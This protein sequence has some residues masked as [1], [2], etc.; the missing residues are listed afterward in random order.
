MNAVKIS[1]LVVLIALLSILVGCGVKTP[2]GSAV[3]PQSSVS[4][5]DRLSYRADWQAGQLDINQQL[6]SG[7]EIMQIIP[8]KG[9]LY[10][11]TSLWMENGAAVSRNCQ[12]LVLDAPDGQWR[13]HHQFASN[14]RLAA[15]AAVTFTT[16][17]QGN[18]ITPVT[19]L[20]AAPDAYAG[21][22]QIFSLDDATDKWVP[23]SL[24]RVFTYSS[25]RAIGFY[26]D[27]VAG[28]D[29]VFAGTSTLGVISGVYDAAAPGRIA[30]QKTAEM[31][32]P[33]GERVMSFAS[34]DGVFYCATSRGIFKRINKAYPQWQ[35]V[36]SCPNETSASGIRGL[37]AVP[38]PAGQ[39]EVLLFSALSIIRRLDPADN[40]RETIELDMKSYLS[41][42]LGVGVSYVLAAYNEFLP[43]ELPGT[44]EK[45][46]LFGFENGYPASTV[47]QNPHLRLFTREETKWY[48]AAE[49]RYFVRRATP[50]G[51]VY[52]LHEIVDTSLPTLVGVRAIA[53]SPFPADK[54]QALYF[55]GF[56]CNSQPSHNTGWIYRAE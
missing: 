7:T 4:F 30:W 23:M 14:L 43:Y 46:W 48:F 15:M 2:G 38:N 54:G 33:T 53:V 9:R 40:Y 56:D 52:D 22:L 45:V 31:Y 17:G 32:A 26:H 49:G 19:M 25:T 1:R 10:A 18:K 5:F 8:Y 24:G 13:L 28:V 21:D 12:V 16:D 6:M 35:Q 50:D 11:S 20:L 51:V 36:Y 37:T 29:M 3:N 39:G 47:Q 41:K 27:P 44:G 34:C 55:G 42:K